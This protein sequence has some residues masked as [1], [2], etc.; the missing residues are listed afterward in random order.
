[1]L[2]L[3][4]LSN[5][6]L[7]LRVVH[8]STNVAQTLLLIGFLLGCQLLIWQGVHTDAMRV[9]QEVLLDQGAK[10]VLARC[11]SS[12]KVTKDD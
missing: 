12:L 4:S 5:H 6:T 8:A 10:D 2:K 9:L 3:Y 7:L 11:K 1:M